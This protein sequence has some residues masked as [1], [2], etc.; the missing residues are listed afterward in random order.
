MKLVMS[1][2]TLTGIAGT[3][4]RQIGLG[5]FVMEA[6]RENQSDSIRLT[7]HRSWML[8]GRVVHQS[9]DA[10]VGCLHEIGKALKQEI[11]DAPGIKGLLEQRDAVIASQREKILQLQAQV[12][13]LVPYRMHYE[14]S[15]ELNHGRTRDEADPETAP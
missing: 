10:V 5:N 15:F 2:D 7:V 6:V 13:G 8:E 4:L 11:I 9:E 14:L 1:N 3:M 12:D